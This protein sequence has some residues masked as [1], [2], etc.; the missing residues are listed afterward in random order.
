MHI[1]TY[2]YICIYTFFEDNQLSWYIP[3]VPA[4]GKLMQEDCL[5]IKANLSGIVRPSLKK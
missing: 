5:M 3:V 2:I 1:Y 4:P